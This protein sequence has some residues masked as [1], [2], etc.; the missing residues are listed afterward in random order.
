MRKFKWQ[1]I[2]FSNGSNS[3]ICTTEKSFNY[4]KKKYDLIPLK[5]G[6]WL[7]KSSDEVNIWFI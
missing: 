3:Y 6:F 2:Q 1:H 5:E 4:M 7:A